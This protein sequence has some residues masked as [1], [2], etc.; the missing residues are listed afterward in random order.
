ML[1]KQFSLR[2]P[3]EA[4]DERKALAELHISPQMAGAAPGNLR[5]RMITALPSEYDARQ[6]VILFFRCAGGENHWQS[7]VLTGQE[8]QEIKEETLDQ[9]KEVWSQRKKQW[10]SC[11]LFF[12][13]VALHPMYSQLIWKWSTCWM[14]LLCIYKSTLRVQ[15]Y[16]TPGLPQR[17]TAIVEHSLCFKRLSA[18]NFL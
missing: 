17:L 12:I 1:R 7:T 18:Q 16:S 13:Q 6:W 14:H 10:L 2:S 8:F 4:L 5:G 11:V 15:H 9:T 3:P